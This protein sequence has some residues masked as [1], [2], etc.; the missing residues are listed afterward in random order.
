MTLLQILQERFPRGYIYK[1]YC[2]IL[3]ALNQATVLMEY[4]PEL[5][6]SCSV[7]LACPPGSRRTC[8]ESFFVYRRILDASLR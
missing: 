5:S 2:V 3:S 1:I 8:P 4:K 6:D 7:I